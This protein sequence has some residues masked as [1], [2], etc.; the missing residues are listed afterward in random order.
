MFPLTSDFDPILGTHF[1]PQPNAAMKLI[2]GRVVFAALKLPLSPWPG[3]AVQ[4]SPAKSLNTHF[5]PHLCSVAFCSPAQ[6]L[7]FS[8]LM[9][10]P[11]VGFKVLTSLCKMHQHLH[12]CVARGFLSR[13][14]LPSFSSGLLHRGMGT[15]PPHGSGQRLNRIQEATW[16]SCYFATDLHEK[17]TGSMSIG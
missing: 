2:Y 16:V 6:G 10:N 13:L 12:V 8:G 4:W 3:F 15:V 7:T 11:L 5:D 1:D 9:E 14:R 17:W